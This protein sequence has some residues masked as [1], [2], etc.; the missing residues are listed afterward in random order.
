M[1][2]RTRIIFMLTIVTA[3]LGTANAVVYEALPLTFGLYCHGWLLA[4]AIILAALSLGFIGAKGGKGGSHTYHLLLFL[5]CPPGIP[6]GR[7]KS[8]A[9]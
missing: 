5:R 1:P 4:L 7:G 9:Y 6:Y 8:G 2:S 3:I